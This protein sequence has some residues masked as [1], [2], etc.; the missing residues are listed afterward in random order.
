MTKNANEQND[1]QNQSPKKHIW[2]DEIDE[3]NRRKQFA[4]ELGGERGVSNQ[5]KHGKYT[6]RERIDLLLDKDSFREVGMLN[7]N[8]TYDEDMELESVLAKN[9]IGGKGKINDKRVVVHVDDF[10]IRGGSSETSSPEKM[11]YL[12][13]YAVENEMPLIRLVDSAGGSIKILEQNQ[14]TKLPGYWDWKAIE[15]MGSIPV[16]AAAL[17]PCAGLGAQKIALAHFSVMTKDTS[18]VFAAGP[19]VVLPGMSEEVSKEDLGGY[20]VHVYKSGLVQNLAE[21]EEDAFEQIRRFLSFMPRS[22][23]HIPPYEQ[24]Q[25]S[26]DRREDKLASIV[27]KER[28]RVY[29]I[30]KIL[31]LVFDHDSL[32]EMGKY[33]GRSQVTMLGRLNGYPVGILANDPMHYG[34]AMTVDSAEKMSKFVDL[35]DNFNIP[36]VNLV[37]QPGTLVGREAEEKGT[38][39]KTVRALMAVTQATVPWCTVFIRRSFGLAGASYSPRDRKPVR[40]AWPSAYWGSI[41]IEGGVEAAFKKEIN[42]AEDPDKHRDEL[43]AY[44]KNFE[45]PYRSAERFKIEEVIDPRDTRR[46]LCEWAEEAYDRVPQIVGVKKRYFRV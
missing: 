1:K 28:K 31:E 23:N 17:G 27:P 32:F 44:Y 24:P 36:V 14:S 15:A 22:A 13:A 26:P 12:D 11:V 43:I 25:D 38:V 29:K 40:F 21:S 9:I 34:G 7:G 8:A 3:L 6:A 46:L 2:Q 20:K 33:F 16:A 19:A 39:G 5:H 41:P 37:D 42:N 30:R 10:T 35:C 18:Q 4:L 45:S